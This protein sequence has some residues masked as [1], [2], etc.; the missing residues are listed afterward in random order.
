MLRP[1]LVV[2]VGGSGGKTLRGVRKSLQ[3]KLE[4][5]HWR[6]GWPEAW[7]FV[8][9]DS[10]ISQDGLDFPAPLLPLDQ[11]LSL[12]PSGVGYEVI[13]GSVKS[14]VD[15]RNVA[16][17]ERAL[18]SPLDVNV[19][20]HMGAGAFRA[21]G[22]A[23]SAASLGEIQ[24]KIEA[25]LAKMTTATASGQLA[26]LT[27]H[28][29]IPVAGAMPPTVVL[30][31]SI[32]GG[33]GAGQF[34]DV[35]EAIKSAGNNEP[36]TED[37]FALLY[38]PDVFDKLGRREIPANALGAISETMSGS[39]NRKLS[40]AS[41]ALYQGHGLIPSASPK[42]RIGP[43]YPYIVGASNGQV[44][45]G[46]QNDV[47]LAVS[48]SIA[49]WMS[50]NK[51]QDKLSA[52]TVTNYSAKAPTLPDNTG[53]RKTGG[54]SPEPAPFSSMGFGRV[55]L[56]LE[57]FFEYSAERLAKSALK[58]LLFKHVEQDQLLAQKTE[59]QWRQDNADLAFGAF[60][61]DSGLDQQTHENNQ[62]LG[63]L[64]PDTNELQARMK[65]AIEQNARGGMPKG[66]H[67]Y[68][69]WVERIHN[70]YEVNIPSLLSDHRGVLLAKVRDWVDEM[71]G[72]ILGLT[73]Q[74]ISR[75]GMPVTVEL[76][77]RAVQHSLQSLTDLEQEKRQYL[78]EAE[79]LKTLITQSMQAASNMANVPPNNPAVAQGIHQAQLALIRRAEAD[80]REVAAEILEDFVRNF[81]EPLRQTLAGSAN[82][83]REAV[84]DQKL[85]DGRSNP[86]SGWP[87]EQDSAAPKRF[88]PAPNERVLIDV[89]RYPA[90]FDRLIGQTV[91]D[92]KRDAKRVVLDEIIMGDYGID[93]LE[94][95]R[96][97]QRW[98]IID[99][100]QIWV[101]QERQYQSRE[102][103]FQAAKFGFLT[104]HT[105][106]VD[107][108]KL[109]LG[110]PGRT[111]SAFLDQTLSEWLSDDSDRS[112]HAERQSKF[113]KEFDAA[114]ASAAP[115]V[116]RNQK[117]LVS[118]HPP[119][120]GLDASEDD[121]LFS[122]IPVATTDDL[123][124]P[125]KNVLIKYHEWRPSFEE[126]FVGRSGAANVR[127]IDVFSVTS[128][129]VQPMAMESL[130]QP[131]AQEWLTSSA[132]KDGRGN[133][134][135]WRR[136]RPLEESIPASPDIWRQMLVGWYVSK[137]FGLIKA[138]KDHQDPS[139]EQKGPRLSMWVDGGKKWVDFPYP[140]F[141]PGIAPTPD[142]L[143]I[144][145]ES[146]TVALVNS[147]SQSSLDP[148]L[149]YQ[150]LRQMGDM[151]SNDGAL[152]T[153]I[154]KGITRDADAPTPRESWAG[155]KDDSATDRKQ[156]CLAYFESQLADFEDY[157]GRQDKHGD[158]R[159]Y[160]VSWQ[161][162]EQIRDGLKL[163]VHTIPSMEEHDDD[164]EYA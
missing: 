86:Y 124:E 35:A 82:A 107:R 135:Q 102:G 126:F 154:K 142:Y 45:F 67:P 161:I 61:S 33:S 123:F 104:D 25:A 74:T 111:F 18:P 55:S 54:D 110:I 132:T 11:Y 65:A 85:P 27:R 52:Y 80:L 68:S 32:A 146:L 30:V 125:L 140:L 144:V 115:L 81:L 78:A 21:I 150:T 162:R 128:V 62:L 133:F 137:L 151:E 116:S 94:G 59:E 97:D 22:R 145:M 129:P 76:I 106:Y 70:G 3:L 96:P 112:E 29:G 75:Q 117:M 43:A 160:P 83:L 120:K 34:M 1:F 19:P 12:V 37:M 17:M 49:T 63:A 64:R 95:L 134:I 14:R 69:A 148:L 41:A 66:G 109:W 5:E 114:V 127:Q 163:I 39:W 105:Q 8:H 56:G 47:Y 99:L 88:F 141:F 136:G 58:A 84:N 13:Y 20:I 53:L 118:I 4:Q 131:I 138:Q 79:S 73:A 153:W 98:T 6:G 93:A 122:A 60:L 147:Y 158:V 28:M 103:A 91:G 100:D 48:S 9:I 44:S 24:E 152:R 46:E 36:W 89:Q 90:E 42:Y 143:G 130:M 156:S 38:A 15:G 139:F 57:R 121:V 72:K 16:D 149:P 10:P 2:G 101:P 51:V 92:S 7:Q 155:K 50:D 31:S 157:L 71:P 40:A 164:D 113:V 87:D 23:I 26:E 119:Q 159:T 77:N 108:A